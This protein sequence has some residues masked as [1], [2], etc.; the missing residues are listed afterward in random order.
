MQDKKCETCVF[1]EKIQ[2][3][4]TLLSQTSGSRENQGFC[5]RYPPQSHLIAQGRQA[6]LQSMVPGTS[7]EGW[8]GEYTK[9]E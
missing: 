3:G 8:C 6:Q 1:W 7:G 5:H 2:Q 4:V 9:A